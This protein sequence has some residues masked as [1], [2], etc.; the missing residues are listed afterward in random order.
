MGEQQG[1]PWATA[2]VPLMFQSCPAASVRTACA[3]CFASRI[4]KSGWQP[5]RPCPSTPPVQSLFA[6]FLGRCRSLPDTHRPS[7]RHQTFLRDEQEPP[8]VEPLQKLTR[9]NT[10]TLISLVRAADGPSCRTALHILRNFVSRFAQA[11]HPSAFSTCS[12]MVTSLQ[13]CAY[14]WKAFARAFRSRT[15]SPARLDDSCIFR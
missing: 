7:A 4:G 11:L 14:R 2:W 5:R 15:I 13:Q 6:S 3:C 8:V 1:P 9:T 10:T 12:S